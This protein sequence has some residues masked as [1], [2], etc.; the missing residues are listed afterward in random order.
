MA[1]VRQSLADLHLALVFGAR[2]F[3]RLGAGAARLAWELVAVRA[4][5]PLDAAPSPRR[6]A[7]TA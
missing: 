2:A 3:I 6:C 4:R 7:P 5:G 1:N